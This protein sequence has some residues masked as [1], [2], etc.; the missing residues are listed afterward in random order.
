MKK[1]LI[2]QT[3]SIG[4]VI[5]ATAVLEKVHRCHP[6]MQIDLLV[7]DGNQGLFSEHP[8]VHELFVWVKKE[9]KYKNLFALISQIRMQRY[10][11]VVNLQRFASSGLLTVFSGA[12]IK[13]GFEKNPLSLFFTKRFKHQISSQKGSPHELDRNQQLISSIT[14]E[15]SAATRLYPTQQNY[16]STSGYKAIEYICIAPSS[17]WFTKQFPEERWVQL[18]K[19]LPSDLQVYLLGANNDAEMCNRIIASAERHRMMNLCGTMSLL[20]SAALM[21]DARMNFVNDSA[22]LHLACAV[23]APVTAVF[24]STVPEFGFGPRTQKSRV[25]ELREK[26]S[27]RPC[28]LHGHKSCPEGHFKCANL[29]DLNELLIGVAYD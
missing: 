12:K 14:D 4:D 21:K 19:L 15:V 23:D 25:V 2:I 28:G 8:F 17:L 16:A 18:I 24:C 27:C 22:P 5:L 13:L 20:D 11:V 10:D 9:H 6:D 26:L 1:I 3:A 29:I 7:K